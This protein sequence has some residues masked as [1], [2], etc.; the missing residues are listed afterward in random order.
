MPPRLAIISQNTLEANG[1]KYLLLDII[2]MADVTDFT[3]VELF[4]EE[5]EITPFFH[6]FVTAQLLFTN[7]DFFMQHVRQTFVLTSR[8]YNDP[9]LLNFHT[10][11]TNLDQ[12]SLIKSLL[13]L[14]QKGHAN[15]SHNN[16]KEDDSSSHKEL[17]ISDREAEVLA[18][19]ARGFINKEIADKLCISLP[20]VVT[21]RK[22][23]CDKLNIRSVSALTIF[24]VMNG[25][26]SVD[27]I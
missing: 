1:L 17:P 5:N 15:N 27:D 16:I 2:P 7:V 22:N 23:I 4:L 3:S 18:L 10:I 25:I 21:H 20:T 14:H 11:N 12:H 19:V 8:N 24:A 9:I 13:Q 6:Y 26:V